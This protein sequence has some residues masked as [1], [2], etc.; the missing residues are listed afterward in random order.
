MHVNNRTSGTGKRKNRPEL[1]DDFDLKRWKRNSTNQNRLHELTPDQHQTFGNC[2]GY[3][4][5][6]CPHGI[7]GVGVLLSPYTT[8]TKMQRGNVVRAQGDKCSKC[9]QS[10]RLGEKKTSQT[11][12][13]TVVVANMAC[14]QNNNVNLCNLIYN[15]LFT[16]IEDP[17]CTHCNVQVRGV[18]GLLNSS[19]IDRSIEQVKSYDP[20]DGQKCYHTCFLCQLGLSDLPWKSRALFH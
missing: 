10:W 1:R 4:S 18:S 9:C 20:E 6:P 8:G 11:K 19:S 7:N 15:K 2:G 5:N 12:H 14:N 3:V 17:Q 16:D 13:R